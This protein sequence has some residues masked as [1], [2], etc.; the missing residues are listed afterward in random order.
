[1]NLIFKRRLLISPK[2]DC[3]WADKMVLNPAMIAD[4]VDGNLIHMLFRATGA[5]AEKQLPGKPLPYPIF[6]GYAFSSDGG[7][8]WLAD[9]SRPAM[10]PALEY[11]KDKLETQDINGNKLINY[12]NGCIEDPRLF[13]F[14]DETYLSVACRA[15]PPGPY[16]E[17]DDPLQCMPEWALDKDHGLGDAVSSNSTVTLLYKVDTGGLRAGD[18][19]S[20]FKLVGPLH[21]PDISDDRDVFLFPRRLEIDGK[22]MIVCVHRPK[23]PWNYVQGGNLKVPSI[24]MAAADT[25]EA[26]RGE[27]VRREVYATPQFPW[28][29]NRIGGSWAP[30]EISPGEWLLPY[31]GKQDDRVGYT[32]SFM[33]LREGGSGFPEI[34][35]RP[36]ERLMYACEDWEL[37]GDFSIPCMFTCSGLVSSGKRLLMGY[38]AADSRVGLVETDLASLL[39][40]L[41]TF[42]A[43]GVCIR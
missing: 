33:I 26:L 34:I 39:D 16:W 40:W 41:R 7:E 28:E 42:D 13:R 14:E 8:N 22:K 4:D 23:H 20:S 18:Y 12:A 9:F 31:H 19:A 24:F 36:S 25:L 15:F 29:G 38:G 35:H 30:L 21:P 6:L 32:Q 37:Q 3:P 2:A 1:M 17:H 5:C 43:M 10:S 27:L 11:D